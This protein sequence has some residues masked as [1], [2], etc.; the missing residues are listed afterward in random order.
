MPKYCK[1]SDPPR[2][3]IVLND[4]KIRMIA[5]TGATCSCINKSTF[6]RIQKKHPELK[7]KPTK[8][9]IFSFGHNKP[10]KPFGKIHALFEGNKT[11]LTETIYVMSNDSL[12]ENI[13]CK[14]VSMELGFIKILGETNT[15]NESISIVQNENIPNATVQ[16]ET[17]MNPCVKLDALLRQYHDLLIGNGLLKNY[18]HK[19]F[20]DNSVTPVAQRFRRYPYQLREQIN[21]ELDKLL[22][23]NFVEKVTEPSDWISNLVVTPKKDGSIRLCLDARPQ[24]K[25]IKRQKYP[26]PTLQSI[27]DDLEWAQ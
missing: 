3:N 14:N 2:V 20:V 10:V 17:I 23:K 27:L 7:L 12:Y 24:N 8:T 11:F 21:S 9:K 13:M 5:D 22:E 15:Q 6:V 26:I 18:K 1:R 25:A 16:P 19:I 4:V